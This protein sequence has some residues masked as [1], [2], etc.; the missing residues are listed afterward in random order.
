MLA[1]LRVLELLAVADQRLEAVEDLVF[2]LGEIEPDSPPAASVSPVRP[3]TVGLD[4]SGNIW[5]EPLAGKTVL[6]AAGHTDMVRDLHRLKTRLDRAEAALSACP[7][8][9]PPATCQPVWQNPKRKK[10]RKKGERE[11][12]NK[13]ERRNTRIPPQSLQSFFLFL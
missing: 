7:C 8:L 6:A 5:I 10:E 4:V 1:G 13:N 9:T 3:G 2:G 12:G 11:R